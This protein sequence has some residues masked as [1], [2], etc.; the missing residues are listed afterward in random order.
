MLLPLQSYH[1]KVR[2]WN[3]EMMAC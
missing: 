2:R 1:Y 3:S